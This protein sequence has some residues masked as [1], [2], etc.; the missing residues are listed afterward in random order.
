MNPLINHF[1]NR[2]TNKFKL[3][4]NVKR[5]LKTKLMKFQQSDRIQTNYKIIIKGWCQYYIMHYETHGT[6]NICTRLLKN[7]WI[8]LEIMVIVLKRMGVE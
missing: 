6:I 1:M 5:I 2:N 3:K 7:V 8:N 4:M